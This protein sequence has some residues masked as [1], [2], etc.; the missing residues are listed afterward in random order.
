MCVDSLGD[1]LCKPGRMSLNAQSCADGEHL[2]EEGEL[3]CTS[4]GIL[5]CVASAEELFLATRKF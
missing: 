1:M 4:M 2:E 3:S 5:L